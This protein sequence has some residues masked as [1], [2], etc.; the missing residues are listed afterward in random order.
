[1]DKIEAYTI[2]VPFKE[3]KEF[4]A[5]CKRAMKKYLATLIYYPKK[6]E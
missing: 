4:K 6:D 5:R 1:M 2:K 3:T